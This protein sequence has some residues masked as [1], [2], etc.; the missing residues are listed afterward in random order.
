VLGRFCNPFSNVALQ[1]GFDPWRSARDR[2]AKGLCCWQDSAGWC[3]PMATNGKAQRDFS[4]ML[5][6]QRGS[7]ALC[8]SS[9]IRGAWEER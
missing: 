4:S 1:G 7:F 8:Y 5:Q 2:R 3:R 9:I 6:C